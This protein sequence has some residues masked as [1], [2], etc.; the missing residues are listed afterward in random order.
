M[1]EIRLGD[2]RENPLSVLLG[3]T[4][5]YPP[6]SE[7]LVHALVD[8][9]EQL[10]PHAQNRQGH[11]G[12]GDVQRD[13]GLCPGEQLGHAAGDVEAELVQVGD[14]G[15]VEARGRD[16][17]PGELPFEHE[18]PGERFLRAVLTC[19]PRS[20]IDPGDRDPLATL[21]QLLQ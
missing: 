12:V 2:E 7:D 18:Q 5:L 6:A 21:G 13:A 20:E 15:E 1:Q 8:Q 9:L 4:A 3:D 16:A 11:D 19:W 14:R 17:V 10:L